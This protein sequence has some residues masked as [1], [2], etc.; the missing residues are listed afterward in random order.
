MNVARLFAIKNVY[1]I[2]LYWMLSAKYFL[3]ALNCLTCKVDAI[4]KNLPTD[5]KEIV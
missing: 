1:H 2:S 3:P 4:R 5:G